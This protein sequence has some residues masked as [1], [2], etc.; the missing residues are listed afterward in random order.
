MRTREVATHP[1]AIAYVAQRS[2]MGKSP[3]KKPWDLHIHH[4]SGLTTRHMAGFE[5]SCHGFNPQ[6]YNFS[7]R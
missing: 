7:R 3:R 2:Q 4:L 5:L 1:Q 6:Q